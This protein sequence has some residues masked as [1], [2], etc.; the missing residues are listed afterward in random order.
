[1]SR[2]LPGREYRLSSAKDGCSHTMGTQLLTKLETLSCRCIYFFG[3]TVP[4]LL[5]T[6]ASA[7]AISYKLK[8]VL[9]CASRPD[10]MLVLL[11]CCICLSCTST[12]QPTT[13]Q[14]FLGQLSVHQHC[15]CNR[16]GLAQALV[17]T[18]FFLPFN[19]CFKCHCSGV[20]RNCMRVHLKASHVY[21]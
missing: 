9:Q 21:M 17:V 20:I 8:R 4:R 1:M 3:S 18:F 15:A 13:L 6:L 19:F 2:W 11:F 7:A 5:S 16:L 12:L 14:Q 10:F